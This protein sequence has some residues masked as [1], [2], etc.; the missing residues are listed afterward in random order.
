[1][2]TVVTIAHGTT[3]RALEASSL[4]WT[5]ESKPPIGANASA[6][7]NQHAALVG[8]MW[9]FGVP[10]VQSGARKLST[11]AKPLGHP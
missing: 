10:M 8:V 9:R 2:L 1:M 6:K 3:T 7:G 11:N 4:M 5:E